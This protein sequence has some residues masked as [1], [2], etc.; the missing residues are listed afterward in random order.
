MLRMRTSLRKP[1]P[2]RRVTLQDVA[3]H[4]G[5]SR[6]T[7]SLVVRD[8]PLVTDETRERVLASMTALGYVY[9]RAAASLRSRRS[10][11][12]GLV[13]TDITNPFFAQM[14]IG[15]EAALE[16]A[17]YAVLLGN[18]SDRLAKQD[19]LLEAMH[20]YAVDGILLAPAT[21]TTI[22]TIERL[23]Q[24]RLPFVLVVRYLFDVEADYVGADNLAGAEMAAEHLMAHG[25][26]RIAFVGG[27]A[28]SS[29]RRDRSQGLRNVL[30][31]HGQPV[32]ESLFI[33]SPVTRDGGRQAIFDLLAAADP[34]TA[35]LCYNDIVAFGVML[36]LQATGRRPGR[37]F[38]VVGFDDIEEA[39]LWQ[40]ALTTVAID[41]QRIGIEAARLLLE[42]IEN[43]DAPPQRV[44]LPPRL[45]VRES[46]AA[47]SRL[48]RLV[49]LVETA[50]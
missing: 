3:D 9:N 49:E 18:T 19:V 33:N 4:A 12:I 11:A 28:N 14:T 43:P 10:H 38:D 46:C 45:I 44:I 13:V 8:S 42:R 5:V 47:C 1:K 23:R 16:E 6:A 32:D 15:S 34:P 48:D 7:A 25:H 17:D 36:G 26:R 2:P 37:D 35:A 31:R 39:A 41:P 20:S 24:W 50:A 22:G 40:P 27:P 30:A 21:D 29:A